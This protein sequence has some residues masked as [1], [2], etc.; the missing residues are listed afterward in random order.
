LLFRR[1]TGRESLSKWLERR[2][3][4]G[5]QYLAVEDALLAG[6]F[7]RYAFRRLS[8]FVL[9]RGWGIALHIVELT[10]LAQ[11]FSAKPFIASLALQ[12]ATLVLDAWFFGALEGLRRRAR[13]LGPG[14]NA[15]ALTTRWLTVALWFGMAIVLVP[16]GR[17]T[18]HWAIDENTPSLFHV[19]ALVCALRLGLDVV[20]RTYYSGVF[21]HNRVYRPLWTPLVPPT[22]VIG[23]T[24]LLWGSV[25]GWGF[26]LALAASVAVSRSLLF[27][28]TRRAYRFRRIVPPRWRLT[29]RSKGRPIEWRMF[30]DALLGGVA[31]TT[32]RLGGVV[33]LA[34][35]VPSLTRPDVFE[36]EAPEVEP[37][38]FA[39]HLA[40]PLLYIAG[41][42]GL[43][44]YHDWKRV[45]GELAETLARHL[46]RRILFTSVVVALFSWA[47]A[48]AL[49]LF[50]V[51]LDEV[52]LTLA[53]LLP[54]MLGLSV[55][56]A[57][58]LRGFARGEFVR[59]VASALSMLLV[60]WLA[61][62]ATFLGTD[63]WYV[64]LGA[65]PWVAVGIYELLGFVKQRP[66]VGEVESVA[67]WERARRYTRAE[68][69][70]WEAQTAQ[71][72]KRV[73]AR[74]TEKLGERGAVVRS[75]NRL[76][77]FERAP[78]TTRDAWLEV[79]CGAL[80]RLEGGGPASPGAAQSKRL[81]EA[82]RLGRPG[83]PGLADV[84][85]AYKRLFPEGFVL[86]IGQTS[87]SR[88]LAL[89]PTVRQAIWRDALRSQRGMRSRSG[90]FVT[91]YAPHGATEVLF[92]APRPLKSEDAAAWYAHLAPFGWRQAGSFGDPGSPVQGRTR[93][94][95]TTPQG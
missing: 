62:S 73:A 90:W 26:P 65:G 85:A 79:A 80:V 9:A 78:F 74:I 94:A 49:V 6:S 54:S 19:Y 3:A 44:F 50:Y 30:R 66:A 86:H 23:I 57:L 36:N 72:P 92:A 29:W 31:N 60:L 87:P 56:T 22:L 71:Y 39:L 17:A 83:E 51:K 88:F 25:G 58:Q 14:T 42:W 10:W 38:A 48:S 34:A 91:V 59:Q 8:A 93:R 32:T 37:F 76:I 33:L 15:A 24:L 11:V 46:H 81:E 4:Q 12:N 77:W 21:A 75:A 40:A 2:A 28:Y 68:V 53:A 82:G 5:L 67:A 64:A 70:I 41:Q 95:K 27:V 20:L 16:I 1:R 89:E 7:P 18:W 55:W 35:V 47:S 61:L 13:E 69:T 84:E 52:W 45:E 43:V 63:A